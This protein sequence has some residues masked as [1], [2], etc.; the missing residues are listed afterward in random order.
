MTYRDPYTDRTNALHFIALPITIG[1]VR[2]PGIKIH[3]TRI[4]EN[5]M[6]PTWAAC[7]AD[8][9]GGRRCRGDSGWTTAARNNAGRC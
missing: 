7:W 4:I 9:A 6:S 1:S 5:P 8:S 3:E 2:Y